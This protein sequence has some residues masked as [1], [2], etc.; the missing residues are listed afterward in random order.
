MRCPSSR[1]TTPPESSQHSIRSSRNL[2]HSQGKQTNPK[3][4]T[5][6][7]CKIRDGNGCLR[8]KDAKRPFVDPGADADDG[9]ADGAGTTDTK[10][11]DQHYR[12]TF[13]Q[14]AAG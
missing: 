14:L 4:N 11:E 9:T 12:R 13:R 3:R 5:V 2:A 6:C 7:R 1:T 10:T 8:G